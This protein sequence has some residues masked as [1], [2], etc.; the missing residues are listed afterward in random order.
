M[1]NVFEWTA[2]T[3]RARLSAL[4]F[5]MSC[6]VAC[7]T[8]PT[9]ES[10]LEL[11]GADIVILG[12]VH[13]NPQH[14]L[15]QASLIREL[16]PS[17]VA[18]EMLTP[19]Q[20]AV[21]ARASRFDESLAEALQWEESG[22]PPWPIYAPVFEASAGVPAYG[23]ALPRE[24]VGRAVTEGAAAV[25]GDDAARFGL[26]SRLPPAEQAEREA[27]QQAVHCN[28]LPDSLLPGMV[29]AQRLRDAAFSRTALRALVETG[30]P[31]VVITG[32][33]HARNDWGMPAALRQ[34]APEVSVL[35]VGQV[36]GEPGAAEPF[37]HWLSAEPVARPDPC[38]GFS[39]GGREPASADQ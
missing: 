20:A 26:A 7:A 2:I 28:A 11:S 24:T 37:D 25:F 19:Q 13:D 18:F 32:S 12:E 3:D 9:P 21:L 15:S 6:L 38:E 14:H 5:L 17:A 39:M 4:V 35:S 36:E 23:M 30:G 16:Q 29:E 1:Y 33:G 34:A 10:T 27:H 22:W 8:G 31:V